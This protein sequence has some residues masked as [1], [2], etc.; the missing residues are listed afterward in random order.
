[1]HPYILYNF[2][3]AFYLNKKEK[4]KCFHVLGFDIILDSKGKPWLLEVNANPS[5]NIEH[6]IY[7]ST[8][9]TTKEDSPLDKY[10]KAKVVGDTIPLVLKSVEKQL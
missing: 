9:K 6:E 3:S 4:P 7:F 5:F 8:G 1:M 10:I 2:K